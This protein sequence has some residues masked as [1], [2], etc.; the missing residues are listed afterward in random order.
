MEKQDNADPARTWQRLTELLEQLLTQQNTGIDELRRQMTE[1]QGIVAQVAGM[2]TVGNVLENGFETLTAQL[3]PLRDLAPRRTLMKT[4]G[5]ARLRNLREAMAV[6]AWTG[7]GSLSVPEKRVPFIGEVAPRDRFPGYG[8]LTGT[9]VVVEEIARD[10]EN[11]P[12]R[13][14]ST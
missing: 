10:E 14:T 3:A 2:N 7:A 1:L 5:Y 11:T 9:F 6:P 13:G 4:D 12:G 8:S